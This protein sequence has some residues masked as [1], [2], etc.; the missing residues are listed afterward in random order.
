MLE[1]ENT[2]TVVE[3]DDALLPDGWGEDDD[4]FDEGSWKGTEQTDASAQEPTQ[5]TEETAA[6]Q[7][8]APATEQTE[9]P[10]EEVAPDAAPAPEQAQVQPNRLKFKARVD[11][12]DLDVEVDESELPTLYEK[13]QATDRYK[14]KLAKMTPQMERV[15]QLAKS[16]GFDG[17]DSMITSIEKTYRDNEVHRLVDEGVHEEVA[18]DMVSRRFA[19]QQKETPV[20][21]HTPAESAPTRDFAAE[22]RVLMEARPDLAGKALPKEVVNACVTQGKSLLVAYSEY[23]VAQ[24]KAEADKLRRENEV[25]KQNAASAA[26]APVSG[27]TGGGAVNTEPEDDFMK[28]FNS[29]F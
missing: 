6:E 26:R 8:E 21:E 24:Q 19:P 4:I 9:A 1:N 18:K 5:Q 10:G 28:G 25:L 22:A 14:A 20:A 23:E 2:T 11:R 29:G 7:T 16:M 3:D 13:A 27:V 15:E 12:Q 17:W